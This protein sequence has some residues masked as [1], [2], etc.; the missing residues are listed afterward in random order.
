[1]VNASIEHRPRRS[2]R[3]VTRVFRNLFRGRHRTCGPC[4]RHTRRTLHSLV[5][6]SARGY[7]VIYCSRRPATPE[8]HN[9]LESVSAIHRPIATYG[10]GSAG[11]DASPRRPTK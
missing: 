11:F 1:M 3:G 9:S 6:H 8:N 2:Q 4:T 7:T 10:V 5:I